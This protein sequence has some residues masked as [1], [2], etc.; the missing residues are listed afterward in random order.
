MPLK[1]KRCEPLHPIIT[2]YF[3]YLVT[4]AASYSVACVRSA[5]IYSLKLCHFSE[6]RQQKKRSEVV[7]HWLVETAMSAHI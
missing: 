6:V 4:P 1:P 3:L 7:P 2:T 5:V